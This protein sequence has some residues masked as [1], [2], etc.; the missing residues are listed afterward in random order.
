MLRPILVALVS[1]VILGTAVRAEDAPPAPDPARIAAARDLMDVTG[2]TKQMDGMV[3]AMIMGFQKGAKAETSEEGK[4]LS[5]EF[6]V[7]MKRFASYKEE[8]LTDFASL[9]AENFTAEEM[10][11]VAD[12]YRSGTGAKFV[13]L[14]PM[15]MQKGAQIGV[16]Y[17][18][19]MMNDIKSK[20]ETK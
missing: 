3:D 6:A 18:E 9:Y 17:S 20:S 19:K 13:Q 8:M 12:F 2:I 15:L 11:S 7:L 16:K 1:F 10:K 5:D 14:T 4:K